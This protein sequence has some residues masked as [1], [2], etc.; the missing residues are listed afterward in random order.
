MHLQFWIWRVPSIHTRKVKCRKSL[1][2]HLLKFVSDHC[3]PAPSWSRRGLCVTWHCFQHGCCL[4]GSTSVSWQKV[5]QGTGSWTHDELGWDTH[6]GDCREIFFSQLKGGIWQGWGSDYG[7]IFLFWATLL[8]CNWYTNL[9]LFI[10]SDEF[11]HT[12]LPV[13]LSA[14]SKQ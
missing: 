1:F 3:F 12:H 5:V 7:I 11:G 8:R 6:F 4:S 10:Q 9:H 13:K 14:Q 2:F